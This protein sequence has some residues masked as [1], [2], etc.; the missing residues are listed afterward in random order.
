MPGRD[1]VTPSSVHLTPF[2]DPDAGLVDPGLEEGVAFVRR[3][4][5]AGLGVRSAAA[6]KVRQPLAQV[7]V[8][9]PPAMLPWLR[10]FEANVLDELNVEAVEAAPTDQAVAD[11]LRAHGRATWAPTGQPPVVLTIGEGP[12]RAGT[13]GDVTVALDTRLTDALQRKGFVRQLVHQIQLLRKAAG[14]AVDDRIHLAIAADPHRL[15]A[16][17]EHRDYLCEETLALDLVLGEP[18]TGFV[19]QPVRLDTGTA[20]VGL[21]RVDLKLK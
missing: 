5:R 4:L 3:V 19:V 18:P 1:P 9:A 12:F 20:V 13:D 15:A 8:L 10:E 11:A 14:L 21:R 7:L 17:D 6:L 16:I 2:P